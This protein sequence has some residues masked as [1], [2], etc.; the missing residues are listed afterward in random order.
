[1]NTL[2]I[3]LQTLRQTLHCKP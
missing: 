3:F 1:V 2:L